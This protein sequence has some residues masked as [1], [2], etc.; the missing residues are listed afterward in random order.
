MGRGE[1]FL[2][3]MGALIVAGAWMGLFLELRVVR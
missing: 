2:A 3:C 1:L